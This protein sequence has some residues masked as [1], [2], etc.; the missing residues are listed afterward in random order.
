M[1]KVFVSYSHDS[2]A[3][4]ARVAAFVAR[5]RGEGISVVYDEDLAGVGGP[6]EGWD[7]WCERQIVECDYVLACCTVMF[8]QRFDNPQAAEGA[9]GVPW[10]AHFIRQYLY[11]NPTANKK[12]RP[13]IFEEGDRGH[14]P[15]A[16]RS[17]SCFLPTDNSSY[18]SLLGWLKAAAIP[19]SATA[20]M[21]IAG[22]PAAPQPPAI[23]WPPR[24]DDFPRRLAD[25]SPEF[26][27]FK[28]ML[29]GRGQQRI[30]LVQG[31][32]GSGKT[33]LVEECIDYARHREVLASHID[34]KGGQSLEAVSDCLLLD[35]QATMPKV[36]AALP[37]ARPFAV[38]ADLQALRTPT[39]I[40]FDTYQAAPQA[41]R[42]WV[43]TQ[44]LPRIARCPAVVIAI[45]GQ[46]IPEHSGRSWAPLAHTAALPPI[47]HVE[48]WVDFLGRRHGRT[49]ISRERIETLTLATNG[50]PGQ[51]S[52]LLGA[53]VQNLPPTQ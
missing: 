33:V 3:H 31:P 44:L 25:R 38:I 19:I 21:A 28:N 36:S 35:L 4:K 15:N 16:L 7:R 18:A 34:F 29:A 22:A 30:L 32:S 8:H 50:D 10:E 51:V 47:L 17:F 23:D 39:F 45:A 37:P 49:D 40:A 14:I 52:A 20:L 41:A 5:L 42:D 43:E 9:R 2:D 48:D 53:L 46:T 6:D 1:P 11:D 12:V 26:D 27:R 13:L 24:A